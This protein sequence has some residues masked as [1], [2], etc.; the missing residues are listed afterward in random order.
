[1]RFWWARAVGVLVQ[2]W[3]AEDLDSW[4]PSGWLVENAKERSER[5]EKMMEN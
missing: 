1:M 2:Q 3:D 4:G 5:L